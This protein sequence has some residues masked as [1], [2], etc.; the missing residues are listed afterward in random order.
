MEGE[1]FSSASNNMYPLSIFDTNMIFPYPEGSLRVKKEIVVMDNCTSQ[2]II[3]GNSYS[4]IDGID[5][6]NHKDRYFTIVE[7]KR[8]KFVFYNMPEKI[9]EVSSNKHI[10]KEYFVLNQHSEAHIHPTLSSKMKQELYDVLY[11]YNDSFSSDNEPLC[12]F[13]GHEVYITLNIYRPYPPLIRR[14]AYPESPRAI[15]SKA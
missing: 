8:Q 10:N 2:H 11:T 13:R 5:I 7:N 3:L 12:A 14:P 1:K 4:N 6:N 15:E 9:S